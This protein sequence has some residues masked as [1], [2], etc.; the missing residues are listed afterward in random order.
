[1]FSAVICF[2][3]HPLVSVVL[4]FCSQM[5]KSQSGFYFYFKILKKKCDPDFSILGVGR[6]RAKQ[7]S[8]FFLALG[9]Q[10]ATPNAMLIDRFTNIKRNARAQIYA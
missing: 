10:I 3:F 8:S 1:M 9:L 2:C 5:L 4:L 6:E 7:T